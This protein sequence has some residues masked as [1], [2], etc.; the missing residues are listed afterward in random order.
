M[1]NPVTDI[2]RHPSEALLVDYA[3]GSIG[4]AQALVIVTHAHACAVCRARIAEAEAMGGALL[5]DLP[6]TSVAPDALDRALAAIEKLA[7]DESPHLRTRTPQ[8]ADW[9]RVP[10]EVAEAA[11]RRRWLAPGVWMAPVHTGTPGGPLSYLLRVGARMRMPRH[12]HRGC[13]LTLVLK[14]A[15]RDGREVYAAGDMAEADDSVVHSPAILGR[16]E[17]VCLVACDNRLVV[18]EWLGKVVQ[19]YAGI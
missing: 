12:T 11:T 5:D 16:E 8:P 19:T 15:F 6:E 13:E 7:P 18:E 1:T 4:P 3:S 14:G 9:I 2:R 17:C 10:E